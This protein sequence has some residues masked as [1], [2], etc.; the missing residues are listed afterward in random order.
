MSALRFPRPDH[1]GETEWNARVDLACV[2]RLIADQG[3]DEVIYNHATLR[4]PG[5][6]RLFLIKR[7]ELLYTEV[8]ASNLVKVSMDDDLDERSGVNRPGFTLHSGILRARPDVQSVIH[9]HTEH[10]MALAGL[11]GGLRML[12]Q[13]AMRFHNRVGYHDYEG[14]TE[15]FEER[16]RI[17]KKLPGNRALILRHHGI[18]TWGASVCEAFVLM[19]HLLGAAKVQL[20][21]MAT[22]EPLKEIAPELAEKTAKQFEAHDRGRGASDWPA[23]LRVADRIDDS[24]RG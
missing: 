23:F 3:W 8:T 12:S 11:P 21:M 18:T 17:A 5:E 9:L 1:I 6:D 20:M 13:A 7:H 22:G 24:Y 16:E 10:G 19:E 14:L 15:S 4:V 2:Y